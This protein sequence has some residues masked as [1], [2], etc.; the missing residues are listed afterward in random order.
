MTKKQQRTLV[1]FCWAVYTFAYLGRYSYNSNVGPITDHYGVNAI[2]FAV[3]TTFF[4]FSYGAGQI[5]NGLLC[6][7]YKMRYIIPAALIVSSGINAAVFFGAPFGSFGALWLVNGICQ[8]VLWPS[9]LLILS[10]HLDE[11]YMRV[12]LVA[13]GTTVGVGT[14]LAY[15]ASALFALFDGF[16][17]SFLLA[18]VVMTTI[19]VFW[20]FCY[21]YMTGGGAATPNVEKKKAKEPQNPKNAYAKLVALLV[22]L[23]GSYAVILN[24]IKDGLGT[25]VPKILKDSYGLSDSLSIVLTLVL[26]VFGAFGA[27][28]AVFAN[29]KV[30]VHSDLLGLFFLATAVLT[31]VIILLLNSSYWWI[32][33]VCFGL[34]AMLMHGANAIVTSVLPLSYGKKLNAGLLAGLL[35]GTC[36]V[37]STLSQIIIASIAVAG[38]WKTVFQVLFFACVF[39]VA[40]SLVLFLVRLFQTKKAASEEVSQ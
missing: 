35:N 25:W 2:L 9:L 26:P 12:A 36:Y 24:F 8:S 34:S 39:L 33:L 1:F 18:A 6:G 11:H 37:G 30:K 7:K 27:T 15:G 40:L 19:G 29:K 3:P 22:L 20:F 4:F 23:Y 14:V 5:A 32:I 28:M 13:M 16:R 17:F 10:R 38:G 31:G 21:P